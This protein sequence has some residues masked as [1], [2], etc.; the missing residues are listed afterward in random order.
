MHKATLLKLVLLALFVVFAVTG[1][2]VYRAAQPVEL[3][4]YFHPFVG[5]E[6][7]LLNAARY[8]NPG[9]EGQ[10]KVRD[11]QFF[12]SNIRLLGKNGVYAEPDSYHLVRFDGAE[13]AFV[14]VPYGLDMGGWLQVRAVR[15]HTGARQ[16][17]RLAR[18][19]RRIR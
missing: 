6:P 18:L 5:P 19:S 4:L 15:R 17:K 2:R 1:W 12:L 9:G 8:S 3:T 7:L 13:L 16:R 11:F 14:I 10:F